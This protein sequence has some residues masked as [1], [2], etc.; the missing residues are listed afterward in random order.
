M[1]GTRI[2]RMRDLHVPAV[3]QL[4]RASFSLPWTERSYLFE[5]NKNETSIPLVALA[6]DGSLLG[7][8]VVWQVEDEA[9]IG[10]IAVASA[11]QRSGLARAL[12]REGLGQAYT[13]G[14]RKAFLE[15]RVGNIPAR[16]L[17]HS[18]GFVDFDL[19]KKYYQDNGEDAVVML[20]DP[21]EAP[22][23]DPRE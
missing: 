21:L 8:I 4:D 1:T 2:E 12:I 22:G 14:A 18:L 15:V 16:T 9:H 23:M 10:T 3:F 6:E 11:H 20:L 17:Y 19:R 13:R 7:F 5:V